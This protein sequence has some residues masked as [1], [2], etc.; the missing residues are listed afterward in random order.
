MQGV[1]N[2]FFGRGGA[3]LK[4]LKRGNSGELLLCGG[5]ALCQAEL[6]DPVGRTSS[7]QFLVEKK[8]PHPMDVLGLRPYAVTLQM[9]LV[10]ELV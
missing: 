1:E 9:N 6:R 4:H 2:Y 10:A 5:A 7:V 8:T 3:R